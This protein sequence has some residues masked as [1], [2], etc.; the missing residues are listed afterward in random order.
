MTPAP[1]QEIPATELDNLNKQRQDL[2]K[3]ISDLKVQVLD[4]EEK[5]TKLQKLED[6]K[7]KVE[8]QILAQT[9]SKESTLKQ[10]VEKSNNP[11]PQA[12]EIIKET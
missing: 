2:E 9:K 4:E 5:Q 11:N 3:Q 12:L 1:K 8:D 7:K 10:D 6:D